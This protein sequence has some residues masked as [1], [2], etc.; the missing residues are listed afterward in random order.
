MPAS[1]GY[2]G[3]S[4]LHVFRTQPGQGFSNGQL[5]KQS[6]WGPDEVGLLVGWN[7]MAKGTCPLDVWPDE[8]SPANGTPAGAAGSPASATATG[9]P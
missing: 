2:P 3:L 1:K 5:F 6:L 9:A 7:L 8:F 4:E